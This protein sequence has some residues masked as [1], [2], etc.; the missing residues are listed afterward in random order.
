M[1][2]ER[3]EMTGGSL[4]PKR[5]AVF[6]G[7]RPG[8][9]PRYAE[10]AAGVGRMLAERGIG[11]VYGG[12]G[13]GLMGALA[14]AALAAGGE[15][16]GVIPAVLADR[17]QAH[18]GVKTMHVVTTMHERKALM[19]RYADAFLALPGGFGTLDELFE[20][21]TWRQLG[22]H[23]KPCAVLDV[24][25]YFAGLAAFIERAVDEG[26]VRASEWAKLRTGSDAGALIDGLL[27]G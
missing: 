27:A 20:A 10:A 19:T 7:A 24:D 18:P 11:L 1:G 12:G 22:Y 8:S 6:C 2:G 3:S 16:I 15:V 5:I 14:D 26:F 9:R 17:E 23:D 4:A 21:I 13:I 25:G